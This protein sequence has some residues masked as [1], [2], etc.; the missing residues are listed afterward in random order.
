MTKTRIGILVFGAFTAALTALVL[1]FGPDT[2]RSRPSSQAYESLTADELIQA[3]TENPIR[4]EST[5]KG[6][7]FWVTGTIQGFEAGPAG[8]RSLH[9][10]DAQPG[11]V[12]AKMGVGHGA[13]VEALSVG[14]TVALLCEGDDMTMA[15]FPAVKGC[16]LST[17]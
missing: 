17:R 11:W 3:F 8:G 4:A 12:F 6:K 2:P 15:Q 9:L 1:N 10:S 7:R 16:Q 13:E 14:Q 5:Y